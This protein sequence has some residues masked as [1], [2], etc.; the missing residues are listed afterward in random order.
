MDAYI[1]QADIYCEDC[2]QGIK[3]SVLADPCLTYNDTP[4]QGPFPNGGGEADSPQH[5]SSCGVFLENPLT[6]DGWAY[7]Q[8]RINHVSDVT[9]TAAGGAWPGDIQKWADFYDITPNRS[10]LPH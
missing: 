4:P 5:C 6:D 2:I 9:G 3:A 7:T 1:Y 10:P 8:R